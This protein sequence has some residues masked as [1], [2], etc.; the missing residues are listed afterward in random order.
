M[1]LE[2][3]VAREGAGGAAGQELGAR[4]GG[5][6]VLPNETYYIYNNF[7]YSCF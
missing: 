6:R 3:P 5:A 7:R 1:G 2:Q 4:A